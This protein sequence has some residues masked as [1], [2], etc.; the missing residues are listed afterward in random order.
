MPQL[1]PIQELIEICKSNAFNITAEDGSKYIS[2]DYDDLR[3]HFDE[4]LEKEK[5]VIVDAYEK[6]YEEMGMAMRGV[7]RSQEYFNN[8][9]KN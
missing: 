8:T 3:K 5:Q 4:L 1:T 9:F 7:E 6:A 2:I